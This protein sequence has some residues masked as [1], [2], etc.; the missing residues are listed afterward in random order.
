MKAMRHHLRYIASTKQL[1]NSLTLETDLWNQLAAQ[2]SLCC[3]K[4]RHVTGY[5]IPSDVGYLRA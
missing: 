1:G 2:H 4:L 3:A 5:L